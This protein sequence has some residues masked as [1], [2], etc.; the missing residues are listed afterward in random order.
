MSEPTRTRRPLSPRAVVERFS[1]EIV[2]KGN[3]E[4]LPDLVDENVWFESSVGDFAQGLEGVKQV[5][6]EMH[7]AF[8]NLAC[9][10]S[11]ILVE[12]NFVAER[13]VFSGTHT[14]EFR[15]IKPTNKFFRMKGM[16]FFEVS[17]G[18]IVAQWGLVDQLE[19]MRQL[20]AIGS[21]PA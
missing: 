21:N 14:G 2:N 8:S 20:G 15:G 5:F 19:M 10:P 13:F 12:D 17:D 1:E 18:R 9:A 4:L 16:T 6:S 11:Q 3:F 7:S